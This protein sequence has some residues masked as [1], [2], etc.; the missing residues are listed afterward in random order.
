MS[1]SKY[2]DS[3]SDVLSMI[4]VEKLNLLYDSWEK[5]NKNTFIGTTSNNKKT[6]IKDHNGEVYTAA[7]Y[8]NI[9]IIP[10]RNIYLGFG[11]CCN[12][13]Q[14]LDILNDFCKVMKTISVEGE[15][16]H[17]QLARAEVFECG[18]ILVEFVFSIGRTV[19]QFALMHS[20]KDNAI[21]LRDFSDR[22]YDSISFEI[23]DTI[24]GEVVIFDY[25]CGN[26]NEY[27]IYKSLSNMFN[28]IPEVKGKAHRKIEYITEIYA[29]GEIN[30]KSWLLKKRIEEENRSFDD[31][32]DGDANNKPQAK[33]EES[34]IYNLLI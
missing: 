24:G 3:E 4:P 25:R 13:K 18:L 28:D 29:N 33:Q 30:L 19:S 22:M 12:S 16:K 26:D 7:G 14:E 1:E 31:N 15:Y 17:L 2:A 32:N 20:D 11:A 9:L 6:L 5:I 21:V 34:T 8:D 23:F 27:S 10:Q